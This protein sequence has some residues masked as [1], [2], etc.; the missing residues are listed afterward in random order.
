[1]VR[2]ALKSAAIGFIAAD[3]GGARGAADGESARRNTSSMLSSRRT[4]MPSL[5]TISPQ[6]LACSQKV[7][8]RKWSLLASPSNVTVAKLS[9]GVDAKRDLTFPHKLAAEDQEVRVREK[10]RR[11]AGLSVLRQLSEVHQRQVP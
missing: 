8:S 11:L 4:G 7:L 3:A 9:F 6:T 10:T 2:C 1:M 5:P